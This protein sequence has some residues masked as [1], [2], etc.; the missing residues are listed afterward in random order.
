MGGR[1]WHYVALL[2]YYTVVSGALLSLVGQVG[3][4][5]V[6]LRPQSTHTHILQTILTLQQREGERDEEGEEVRCA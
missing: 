4:G 1:K 5:W 3:V 2:S 6:C